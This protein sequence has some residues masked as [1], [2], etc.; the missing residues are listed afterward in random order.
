V[1]L[2]PLTY[3]YQHRAEL[4]VVVQAGR[5]RHVRPAA[6]TFVRGIGG[7]PEA[8]GNA[9]VLSAGAMAIAALGMGDMAAQVYEFQDQGVFDASEFDFTSFQ[10]KLAETL[11]TGES[12][13]FLNRAHNR[14]ITDAALELACW[15]GFSNGYL[16]RLAHTACLTGRDDPCRCGSGKQFNRCCLN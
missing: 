2:S 10:A 6:E 1:T 11:K 13:W 7:I 14:P 9:A 12:A 16:T 3:H 5:D 8:V 15:Y 4:E